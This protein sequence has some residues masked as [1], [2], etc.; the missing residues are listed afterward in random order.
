MAFFGGWDDGMGW[1]GRTRIKR[2]FNYD[3]TALRY[4][5]LHRTGMDGRMAGLCYAML[6]SIESNFLLH[7]S[8]TGLKPVCQESRSE[9]FYC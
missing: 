1:E 4:T 8:S 7:L 6:A 5:T 3:L 9:I 2:V